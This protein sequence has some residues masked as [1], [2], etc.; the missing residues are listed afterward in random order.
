[1]G[2]T[3]IYKSTKMV[4]TKE[5]SAAINKLAKRVAALEKNIKGGKDIDNVNKKSQLNKFT[6]QELVQWAIKKGLNVTVTKEKLVKLIWNHMTESDSDSDSDS[7]SSE[8][9]SDSS[10]SDSDSD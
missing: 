8:S 10:D 2:L 9:E 1:M 3:E 5:L 7:D 4:S 6:K